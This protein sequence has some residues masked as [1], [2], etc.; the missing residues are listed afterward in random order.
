[1]HNMLFFYSPLLIQIYWITYYI[2]SL[3]GGFDHSSNGLVTSS[4][5]CYWAISS[6]GH[7]DALWPI[8]TVIHQDLGK[9]KTYL[10]RPS[11]KSQYQK[12]DIYIDNHYLSKV[13]TKS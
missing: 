12:L 8:A 1:M 13:S 7:G 2:G 9:R 3:A 10:Q 6:N 4:A 5:H 11:I